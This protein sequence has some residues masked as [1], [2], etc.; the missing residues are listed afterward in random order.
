MYLQ[1]SN[2]KKSL[3]A[4]LSIVAFAIVMLKLLANNSAIQVG[5]FA[6]AF[7]SIDAT[8]VAAVLGPI[9]GTYAFRRY[10]DSRFGYAPDPFEGP[11]PYTP[12]RS[13][14]VEEEIGGGMGGRPGDG[15]R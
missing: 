7:G 8:T 3:T 9:L 6:Y 14:S 12:Y 13:Y 1:D 11:S 4:T 10:T 5:S 2:G 15:G